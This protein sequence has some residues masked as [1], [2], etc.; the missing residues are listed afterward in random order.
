MLEEQ[1][2]NQQMDLLA[3]NGRC[4]AQ[5]QQLQQNQAQLNDERMKL[6]ALREE[7]NAVQ[8]QRQQLEMHIAQ[9]VT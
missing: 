8:M 6:H 4:H 3:C 5:G 1:L 2:Q 9:E 7:L